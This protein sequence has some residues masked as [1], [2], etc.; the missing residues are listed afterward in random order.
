M[1]LDA[2]VLYNRQ[3]LEFHRPVLSSLPVQKRANPLV[4]VVPGLEAP[5]ERGHDLGEGVSRVIHPIL[6]FPN[7]AAT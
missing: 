1:I 5:Y 4:N 6:G 7:D 3:E 2:F